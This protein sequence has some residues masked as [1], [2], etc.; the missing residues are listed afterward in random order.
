MKKYLLIISFILISLSSFGQIFVGDVD[1]NQADSVSV[2][3]VYVDRTPFKSVD[4]YVDFGQ[5]DNSRAGGLGSRDADLRIND[6]VTKNRMNFKSTVAVLNYFD[7]NGWEQFDAN[8]AL[9]RGNTIGSFFY[10][11]RKNR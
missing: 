5:K 4:V 1:I 7:K 6:P 8:L 11:R 9:M 2:I 3:E 10:F